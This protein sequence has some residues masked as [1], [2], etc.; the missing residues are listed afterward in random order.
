[1]IEIYIFFSRGGLRPEVKRESRCR[2]AILTILAKSKRALVSA[3]KGIGHV[4]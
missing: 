1:M 4:K 3:M 2:R